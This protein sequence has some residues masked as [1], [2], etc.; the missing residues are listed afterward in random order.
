MYLIIKS[1]PGLGS[2]YL[3]SPEHPHRWVT[4]PEKAYKFEH[5][6]D[7][8]EE[9]GAEIVEYIDPWAGPGGR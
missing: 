4:D 8:A 9:I 5:A 6:T 7:L 2:R 1:F 3:D